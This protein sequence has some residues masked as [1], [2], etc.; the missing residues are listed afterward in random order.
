MKLALLYRG[1]TLLV[2]VAVLGGM[3]LF[4]NRGRSAGGCTCRGRS[5][6]GGCT[7]KRDPN[8][9]NNFPNYEGTAD[10]L[11]SGTVLRMSSEVAVLGGCTMS[12]TVPI[13]GRS[14]GMYLARYNPLSSVYT[15]SNVIPLYVG[16]IFQYS[17]T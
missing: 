15:T 5:A 17:S 12:C 14:A 7:S 13:R 11:V 16:K 8:N 1:M 3:Y 9:P 4:K 6:G 10:F 2:V